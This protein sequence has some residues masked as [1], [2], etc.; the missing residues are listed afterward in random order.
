MHILLDYETLRL[1]WW[2]LLGVLLIGFA[3]MDGFDLGVA[4][5]LPFVAKSD[6]ERRV[7]LNTI[8]PVW[9]GNQVWFILGGGAIFA[10]WPAIYAVA[11][12]GFYLALF[13]VLI[14]LI[15]RPVGF[16]FRSK[17]SYKVWRQS[18]DTALFIGGFAAALLFG[19]AVGNVLLGIPFRF[20]SELR[21]TL[22][23][24][25][26]S[27]LT[28]FPLVAG[29]VSVAMLVM[30]GAA[31]LQLKTTGMIR[32]RAGKYG[33]IAALCSVIFFILGG[34]LVST[35]VDGYHVTSAFNGS[36]ASNPLTKEVAQQSGAWLDNY[37][38]YPWMI[39]APILGILAGLCAAWSLYRGRAWTSFIS[40]ALSITG[41]IGTVGLSMF[42][43]ILPSSLDPNSSLT[44]FDASSS[45]LTLWWMLLA[46]VLFLPIVLSYTAWVFRVMRGPVT[47]ENIRADDKEAY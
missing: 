15:I 7:L 26:L 10:A 47:I 40:T 20:D 30:H 25:L 39:T 8:G 16:K 29:L 6:D 41:I 12:S 2:L 22:E 45:H 32:K 11:F 44:V 42:P 3:V 37:H 23:G 33:F 27:L 28:P 18:W 24:G 21:L 34:I 5:L 35:I 36:G 4:A 46:V 19:V 13:A 14:T 31:F 17:L 9:E 1:I 43:I 38:R